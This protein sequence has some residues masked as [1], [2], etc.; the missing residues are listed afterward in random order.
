MAP[1]QTVIYRF[2]PS[3]KPEWQFHSMPE[4]S[5]GGGNTLDEVRTE[6]R[7]SLRFLLDTDDL[8]KI[9][10]YVEKQAHL[11]IWVRTLLG[12][13][14]EEA[15]VREIGEQIASYPP[16]DLDNFFN[17]SPTAGGDAVV[18]HGRPN[19]PLGSVFAQMTPYDSLI[20]VTGVGDRGARP[21]QLMWLVI[22][23]QEAPRARDERTL[24]MIEMGLTP[25]SPLSEV[26]AV[27]LQ[28]YQKLSEVQSSSSKDPL[29][30]NRPLAL[31]VPA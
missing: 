26:Y 14:R 21:E 19:D 25:R 28:H 15:L 4:S 2:D 17:R 29:R 22:T 1:P 13:P 3:H 7:E 16:E 31:L 27:A 6:Y 12:D 20:L 10:E 8:P 11:G 24:D 9:R 18:F 30:E 5:V 23:G